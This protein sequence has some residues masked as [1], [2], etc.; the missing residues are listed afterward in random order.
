[1]HLRK[2]RPE[3]FDRNSSYRSLT[4]EGS[5]K[6]HLI[7]YLRAES[8][9]VIVSRWN[10]RLGGNFSSTA[11]TLPEGRWSHLLTGETFDGGSLRA[12]NLLRRF[13]V[14]LLV[15]NDR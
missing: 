4:V 8:V 6:E 1:L 7:A 12:Q 9:A 5:K 14:A 15:R 2:Q 10:A 3:W 11:V 13:P